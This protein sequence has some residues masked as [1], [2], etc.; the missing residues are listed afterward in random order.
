MKKKRIAIFATIPLILFCYSV[1]RAPNKLSYFE[2]PFYWILSLSIAV[3]VAYWLTQRNFDQRRRHD[4]ISNIIERS[5]SILNSKMY[6]FQATENGSSYAYSQGMLLKER[7]PLIQRY[8]KKTNS[9]F[10]GNCKKACENLDEWWVIFSEVRFVQSL[11]ER[12]E[13]R[14]RFCIQKC[15]SELETIQASLFDLE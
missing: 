14:M 11:Q 3:F 6:K 5:L 15:V 9:K 4:Y 13:Y 1:V 2:L 10:E 7:L 12:E 8:L